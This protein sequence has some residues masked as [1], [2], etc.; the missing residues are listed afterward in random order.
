[1]AKGKFLRAE[2]VVK[3]VHQYGRRYRAASFGEKITGKKLS[4]YLLMRH[5]EQKAA[6]G[7]RGVGGRDGETE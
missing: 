4:A 7:V 5:L 1:M 3:N 2:R 6:E